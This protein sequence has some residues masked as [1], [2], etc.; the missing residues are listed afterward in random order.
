ME[1]T[2]T[3]ASHGE[4]ESKW[5][6]LIRSDYAEIPDL[7][8]TPAQMQRFWGIDAATC[9]AVVD[10]L[11]AQQALKLTLAGGYTRLRIRN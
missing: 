8:L 5:L 10:T 2:H 7:H 9:R 11:L 1:S 6:E 3:V 4:S